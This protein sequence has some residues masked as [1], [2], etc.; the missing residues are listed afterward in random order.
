MKKNEKEKGLKDKGKNQEQKLLDVNLQYFLELFISIP[1]WIDR[2]WPSKVHHQQQTQ[3]S[4][5]L[6]EEENKKV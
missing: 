2:H 4:W 6:A 5:H 3:P 1:C